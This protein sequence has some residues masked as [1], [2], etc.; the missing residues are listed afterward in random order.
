MKTSLILGFIILFMNIEA[1]T[2]Q[3]SNR[4]ALSAQVEE[5]SGLLEVSGRLITHNDSGDGPFLYE[6]DSIS[7]SVVRKVYITNAGAN[8][9]EDISADNQFIYIG[10]FGNNNGTRTN[11]AIYKISRTDFLFN[12]TVSAEVITFNYSEQNS[13]SSNPF[14]PF[15][16][17]A[18]VCAGDSIYLFTKDKSS[19]N[20]SVYTLP[21]TPGNY[22]LTKKAVIP[23]PGLVTGG[24]FN[25][26]QNKI[27]LC[28]YSI[29]S[30]FI[31]EI[32]FIN[33]WS[34]STSLQMAHAIT[35]SGPQQVEAIER[36]DVNTYYITSEKDN[37][38]P[39]QLSEF[40]LNS[41][42]YAIDQPKTIGKIYPNPSSQ[43]IRVLDPPIGKLGVLN[44]H[45]QLL[46]ERN[47][48]TSL[49]ISELPMGTYF[50]IWKGLS[51][52][53]YFERFS[54]LY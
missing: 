18:I 43:F 3:T 41:T 33:G 34:L 32:Q 37:S 15:D 2:I 39:A 13:F 8:D 53:S 30:V 5:T 45:G 10:D 51:G 1:Q 14:T 24:C 42:L 31:Y 17:E 7:G 6:V 9:W 49:D 16:A 11:L 40:K 35:V 29:N 12:D 48:Q 54:V 19:F 28:G 20:S 50:A 23:T 47:Y 44:L 4:A 46:F 21:K 26:L 38:L 36:M 52:K 22:T 27:V 25:G